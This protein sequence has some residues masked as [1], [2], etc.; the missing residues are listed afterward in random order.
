MCLLRGQKRASTRS[1]ST[2][3]SAREGPR[4][5]GSPGVNHLAMHTT[6]FGG[7]RHCRV[8]RSGLEVDD[9]AE[10]VLEAGDCAV[11]NGTRHAWH[12]R[13]AENC[14]IAFCLVG[15][16]RRQLGSWKGE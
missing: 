14:V 9:G 3:G 2:R 4:R 8:W 12:Y 7:F 13:S 1:G 15:A 11:Q 16:E 6:D 10:A 5:V